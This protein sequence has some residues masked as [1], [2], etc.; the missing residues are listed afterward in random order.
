ME[1]L[2]AKMFGTFSLSYGDTLIT[3]KSKSSESQ[4]N[5]LMQMLIHAG[6]AGVPKDRLVSTL[7]SGR[8]LNNS[9]HA[10]H[11]VIYNRKR[12]LKEFGL[13]NENY[14]FQS[15][16]T[17]YFTP[18]ITVEEDARQ[19]EELVQ[20]ASQ[21]EDRDE[22][23]MA[24]VNAAHLYEGDFLGDEISIG[25]IARESYRYRK[26][27]VDM[28]GELSDLIRQAERW[29]LLEDLGKLAT[30]SQPFSNWEA[31]IMEAYGE[32]GRYDEAARL[33]E[34]TVD[35]YLYEQ[36]I[37][38]SGRMFEL[39]NKLGERFE[40]S[41]AM[42]DEIQDGLSEEDEPGGG[43]LCSYPV[44]LGIYQAVNRI[45]ERSG[46]T[47]FLML[48]TI[49]D[50]KGNALVKG[51]H[52]DELSR[53]LEDSIRTSVRRSDVLTKYS[54]GQYLVM[55]MNTSLENCRI[56]QKRIDSKFMINRQRI[57]IQYYVNS[58]IQ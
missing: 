2:T 25:W 51:A 43:Y 30:R 38:P 19:F 24:L 22:K 34:D 6:R 16:G 53:R 14:I 47:A 42:L 50:T 52:L 15:G 28:A 1:K 26:M 4:F 31:L 35:L 3:G 40:H 8:E 57:S 27:F 7:F 37:K 10:L 56:I 13:P 49:V 39:L 23:I 29:D 12:R 55:L 18:N 48:C 5:Y 11:S 58:V 17:Y 54:K 46:Q 33:F 32:Q 20:S 9:S 21:T 44:F 45:L 41:A 36:G